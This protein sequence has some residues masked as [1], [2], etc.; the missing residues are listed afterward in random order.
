MPWFIFNKFLNFTKK[1]TLAQMFSCELHLF[2][3]TSLVAAF[4]HSEEVAPRCF[5]KNFAKFTGK[6]CFGVLS[7]IKLQASERKETS[8]QVFSCEFC[9]FLTNKFFYRTPPVA[10]SVDLRSKEFIV[11]SFHLGRE[12]LALFSL[13]S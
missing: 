4:V 7:L 1:E 11:R 13:F 6:T 10:A 5:L 9:E 3:R 2:Y 12:L 8:T